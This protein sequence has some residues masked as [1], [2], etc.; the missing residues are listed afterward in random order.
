MRGNIQGMHALLRLS[1]GFLALAA[2]AALRPAPAQA[3]PADPTGFWVT[4]PNQGLVQIYAC[5][6][7]TLCGALVGFP[8]DHSTDKTPETWSGLSQCRYVFIRDLHPG[9]NTW[10]GRI[11]DPQ[12]GRSYDVKLRLISPSELWLRG[13]LIL[14]MLGST[15]HWMRYEGPPPPAD[16]RMPA[17]SLG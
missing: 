2:A 13:Y 14:P 8:M 12:S 10:G 3:A 16:C 7:N 4:G 6:P 17:H 9:T 1:C 5:G 15:R 11:T